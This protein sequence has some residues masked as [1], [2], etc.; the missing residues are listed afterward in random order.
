MTRK[1]AVS[2]K[3][4]F[5]N[6]LL[7]SIIVATI[8]GLLASIELSR[9]H[10]NT[11]TNPEYHSLCAISEDINCE[12]VALSS[13]SI[14]AGLPLSI[15]G[16]AGYIVILSLT[17][18]ALFFKRPLTI[19][20]LSPLLFFTHVAF[21][22]SLYLAYVSATKIDSLCIYCTATYIINAII[23]ILAWIVTIKAN[24]SIK[25]IISGDILFLIK[26]P[27]V[28][29]ALFVV[30]SATPII[31]YST[32]NSYWE[33]ALWEDITILNTGKVNGSHY[34]GASS[35]V[36]TI[37]EYTDYECPYCRTSHRNIREILQKYDD[38][39]QLVHRHFPLDDACNPIVNREFNQHSCM[40]S[41]AAECAAAQKK[42][43]EMN[44]AIFSALDSMRVQELDI[45]RLALQLGLSRKEFESCLE[46]KQPLEEIQR[47]I[48]MGIKHKIR[49]TPTF[50]IN[51]QTFTGRITEKQILE[52]LKEN[53]K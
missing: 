49:A 36:I 34:M 47:Q 48:Q 28:T 39:I 25:F 46:Q 23:L 31:A 3:L 18:V 7:I 8:L 29:I 14:F 52:L 19:P 21:L 45:K 44:D 9:I 12:T 41:M 53:K 35:P 2:S 38:Q 27:F 13:Y 6:I 1:D 22:A 50:I 20:L 42:F 17:V 51:N 24:Q 10:Y 26:K 4:N 32:I 11:H 30:C 40:L 15:W 33:V 5:K 16:I 43:W 37:Y